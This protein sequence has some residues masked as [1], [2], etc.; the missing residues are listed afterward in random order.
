MDPV[1]VAKLMERYSHLHPLVLHRSV[2][3]AK[4]LGELFDLLDC[5]PTEM[6]VAW[7]EQER[8]W[9]TTHLLQARRA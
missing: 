9:T 3:R 1:V 8:K 2:E 6:P 5:F 4:T 7:D